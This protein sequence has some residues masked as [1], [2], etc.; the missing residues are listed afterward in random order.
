M[1]LNTLDIA[2]RQV[3]TVLDKTTATGV[4]EKE[5]RGGIP[6]VQKERDARIRDLVK[7]HINRFP[8]AESHYFQADTNM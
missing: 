6:F 5:N 4:L 8:R 3:W 7:T 1:F 2:E